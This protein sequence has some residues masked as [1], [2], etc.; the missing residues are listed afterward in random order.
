MVSV[1]CRARRRWGDRRW[2]LDIVRLLQPVLALDRFCT[3]SLGELSQTKIARYKHELAWIGFPLNPLFD[4]I[5]RFFVVSREEDLNARHLIGIGDML[6]RILRIE[7]N[8]RFMACG[9]V[10]SREQT[11][12]KPLTGLSQGARRDVAW[13]H[14]GCEKHVVAVDEYGHEVKWVSGVACYGE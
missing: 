12:D 5:V 8:D 2:F 14:S 9:C 7:H 13:Y 10:E 1:D 6:R 4:E 11:L 3:P